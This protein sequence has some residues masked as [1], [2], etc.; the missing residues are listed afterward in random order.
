LFPAKNFIFKISEDNY[1]IE[2]PRKG[3]YH[4]LAPEIFNEDA[5]EF[6]IY[7]EEAKIFYLPSITKVLFATSQYPDLKF[8]Q[9]FVPYVLKLDEDK[10]IITGQVVDMMVKVDDQEEV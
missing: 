8:N 4:E 1:I 3:K 10:V 9:F 7:D 6:N 5:G 2:I